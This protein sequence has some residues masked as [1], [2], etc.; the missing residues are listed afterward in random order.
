MGNSDQH[1][2][3][4]RDATPQSSRFYYLR[5][6]RPS[7]LRPMF[8]SP[9][10]APGSRT[11]ANTALRTAGLI[12]RDTAMHDLTDRPGG[13]KGS[14]KTRSHTHRSRAPDVSSKKD[15]LGSGSRAVSNTVS[16]SSLP[17]GNNQIVLYRLR[18]FLT[19][20]T[21]MPRLTDARNIRDPVVCRHR[22]PVHPTHSQLEVL[23][24]QPLSVGCDVM[25]SLRPPEATLQ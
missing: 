7:I 12:D 23:H 21:N 20:K 9:T 5:P 4:T 11:L 10:P 2:S 17:H 25:P 13:R 19:W 3:L 15:L 1:C 8:S 14:S 22:I 24:V 18:S 6:L 16:L